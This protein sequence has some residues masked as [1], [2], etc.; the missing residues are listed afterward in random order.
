[1]S[2]KKVVRKQYQAIADRAAQA[3]RD[4]SVPKEG[5]IRTVRKSLG[6]SGAQLGRKL[7]VTRAYI[8]NTERAE[9]SSSVTLKTLEQMAN[10]MDCRL[11]YAIVP[12]KDMAGII[13][14][15]ATEK[16]RAILETTNKHMALEDQGLSP[17]QVQ[18][19]I[20][21]LADEMKRDRLS[22]LWD[23]R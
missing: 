11:V 12:E 3:A 8:S 16:A 13:S 17:N 9:L 2:I 20:E 18:S 15:K 21:R 1:M 14:K 22:E 19:E 5:W 7:G 4:L 6:M 10:A 23:E